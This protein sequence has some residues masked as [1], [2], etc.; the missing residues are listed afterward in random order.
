LDAVTGAAEMNVSELSDVEIERAMA[1]LYCKRHTYIYKDNGGRIDFGLRRFEGWRD[2]LT[3][4]NLTMPL[5][6]EHEL[7]IE[8]MPM[9]RVSEGYDGITKSNKNP[10]RAICEVLIMIAMEKK[11]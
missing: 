6:V 4:Y 10:L 11:G 8:F 5:A 1:W 7:E 3:D 9:T 2:Y